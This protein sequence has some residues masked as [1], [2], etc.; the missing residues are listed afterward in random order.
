MDEQLYL[1]QEEWHKKQAVDNFNET[2]D[3]IDQAD[4]TEQENLLMIHK[5]HASRYHWGVIGGPLQFARGEW[6]ISRVYALLKHG[7]RAL[8]HA[9]HS[10][11]YCLNH[12]IGDF[13]LAF[14]YEAIARAYMTLGNKQSTLQ[15]ISLAEEAAQQIQKEADKKYFLL[16][17]STITLP[18]S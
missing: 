7:D 18:A 5:A 11:Q 10:L 15:Y 14:A 13:D 16:E 4:R 17:L 2:W 6:Q 3:L 8:Y 9:Q 12:L 1:T